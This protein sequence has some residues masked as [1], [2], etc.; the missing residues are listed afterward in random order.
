MG[1]QDQPEEIQGI[2][3]TSVIKYLRISITNTRIFLVRYIE[4]ISF[5]KHIKLQALPIL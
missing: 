1:K 3:V 2:R 5:K 4:I